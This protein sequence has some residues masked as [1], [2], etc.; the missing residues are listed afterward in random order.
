MLKP[1]RATPVTLLLACLLL[2]SQFVFPSDAHAWGK[3]EKKKNQ[4][5]IAS[6][7]GRECKNKRTANGER[8]DPSQLT[9][10]H[11]TL[12]FGTRV[13]VTNLDNGRHVVVRIND[14][15]PYAKG[16]VLDL[17]RAAASKLGFVAV[18]TARVRLQVLKG[19]GTDRARVA[20]DE[21]PVWHS[22]WH[23]PVPEPPP[24]RVAKAKRPATRKPATGRA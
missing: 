10:A 16:R 3:H 1:A 13:K 14:R 21:E 11:R 15:G 8:F 6:F 7:Y 20:E 22:P 2:G 19:W 4:T 17:S 12:P 9:A 5:G 23:S 18:G 24:A